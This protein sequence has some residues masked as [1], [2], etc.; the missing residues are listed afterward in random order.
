MTL[1]SRKLRD[2][3]RVIHG[4]RRT[5]WQAL[6]REGLAQG[7]SEFSERDLD[8]TSPLDVRAA[9]ETIVLILLT[10][11]RGR[12][13]LLLSTA[14]LRHE[15]IGRCPRQEHADDRVN[16]DVPAEDAHCVQDTC[17]YPDQQIGLVHSLLSSLPHRAQDR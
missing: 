3:R 17:P 14:Q 2:E 11:V 15:Q 7:G 13:R 4:A 16:D 9:A 8:R 1:K 10:T 12:L 5:D 6:R